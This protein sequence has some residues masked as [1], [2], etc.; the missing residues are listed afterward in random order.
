MQ[1]SFQEYS[2]LQEHS[3]LQEQLKRDGWLLIKNFFNEEE[4]SALRDQCYASA[5][6]GLY[7]MDLLSN[8]Y[9]DHLFL[10]EKLMSVV[11]ELLGDKPVYFGDSS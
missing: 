6:A 3:S 1:S 4:V 7:G 8:K 9:L 10:N 11:S 2:S 5:K